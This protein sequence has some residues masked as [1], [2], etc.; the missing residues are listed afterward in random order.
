MSLPRS[1]PGRLSR[2]WPSSSTPAGAVSDGPGAGATGRAER[3]PP[4]PPAARTL[5]R[6]HRGETIAR[7]RARPPPSDDARPRRLSLFPQPCSRPACAHPPRP[8]PRGADRA[9]VDVAPWREL[10]ESMVEANLAAVD[11]IAVKL[12][13]IGCRAMPQVPAFA[14]DGAHRARGRAAGGGRARAMDERAPGRWPRRPPVHGPWDDLDEP[15]KDKDRDV[16]RA[17]PEHLADAGLTI[18]RDAD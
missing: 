12:A 17:I 6:P 10:D 16:V 2:R 4:A 14:A 18:V 11:H 7:P 9:G 1:L 13:R 5:E 8:I 15:E 3:Q